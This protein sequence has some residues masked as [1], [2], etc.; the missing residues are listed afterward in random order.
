MSVECEKCGCNLMYGD[1]YDFECQMCK[2]EQELAETKKKLGV[3]VKALEIY[4]Q[5]AEHEYATDYTKEVSGKM[6]SI[7]KSFRAYSELAREA[8]EKIKGVE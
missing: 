7:T 1:N 4:E 6:V 2:L 5:G 3:A 8:L